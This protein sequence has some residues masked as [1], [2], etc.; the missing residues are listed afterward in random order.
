MP[1]GGEIACPCSRTWRPSISRRTGCAR[2]CRLRPARSTAP[3]RCAFT[4][5]SGW[6]ISGSSIRSCARSRSTAW[7]TRAGWWRARTAVPTPSAP[8]RSMRS[9]SGWRAGGSSPDRLV[10]SDTELLHL[11]LARRD[12]LRHPVLLAEILA[13]QA[14][15]R[16][17]SGPARRA[18]GRAIGELK[19]AVCDRR[20]QHRPRPASRPAARHPA[21]A[22]VPRGVVRRDLLRARPR[23]P[24]LPG[25]GRAG[26]AGLVASPRA[27]RNP[28]GRRSRHGVP[29][30]VLRERARRLLRVVPD[31][32][33][34]SALERDPARP[35]QLPL[36]PAGPRLWARS[37]LCLRRGD[38]R[39][40]VDVRRLHR[41][42]TAPVRPGARLAPVHVVRRYAEA[43]PPRWCSADGVREGKTKARAA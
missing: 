41:Y 17:T 15:M 33:R 28:L 19:V 39:G 25:R 12:Y 35:D 18:V 42:C 13:L 14:L 20:A 31:P 7:R 10:A 21:A 5:A 38:A 4:R 6:R 36:P 3:A 8:S 40:A 43:R 9:S 2:S 11:S 32:G 16:L 24:R 37:P 27:R 26:P 30:R 23:A 22:P 1:G 29:A 34:V